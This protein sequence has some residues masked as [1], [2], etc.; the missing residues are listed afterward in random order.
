[1][2]PMLFLIVLLE[3]LM[4]L[5]FNC[6]EI[7]TCHLCDPLIIGVKQMNCFIVHFPVLQKK[8]AR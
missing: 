7:A 1:M 6:S 5:G 8:L 4:M 2:L 3:H